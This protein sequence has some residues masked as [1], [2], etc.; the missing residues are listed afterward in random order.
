ML[1]DVPKETPS[2]GHA[3]SWSA[4]SWCAPKVSG[5]TSERIMIELD[6]T[7]P[8][9]GEMA[10]VVDELQILIVT[11]AKISQAI[12]EVVS[13]D[14]NQ[15]QQLICS[16]ARMACPHFVRTVAEPHLLR[17]GQ[18]G[19][20]RVEQPNGRA[21]NDHWAEA[22][23]HSQDGP[24]ALASPPADSQSTLNFD[25]CPCSTRTQQHG[26]GQKLRC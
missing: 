13:A 20:E 1:V 24:G 3:T 4:F 16:V 14:M 18:C 12:N 22:G 17:I 23:S 8:T 25:A 15:S 21:K 7:T 19:S 6:V 9:L 26:S 11:S 2:S 10:K 5:V